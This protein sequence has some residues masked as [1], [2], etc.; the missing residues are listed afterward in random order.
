MYSKLSHTVHTYTQCL[1]NTMQ[2]SVRNSS[3]FH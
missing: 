3:N 1:K 2:I